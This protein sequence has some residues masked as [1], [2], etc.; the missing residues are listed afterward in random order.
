M[1]N[2]NLAEANLISQPKEYGWAD[3]NEIRYGRYVASDYIKLALYNF[4]HSVIPTLRMLEVVRWNSHDT[5]TYD[6][7]RTRI[8]IAFCITV[9]YTVSVAVNDLIIII[10]TTQ[11]YEQPLLCAIIQRQVKKAKENRSDH[12]VNGRIIHDCTLNKFCVKVWRGMNWFNTCLW[13]E[14]WTLRFH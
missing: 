8:A 14:R 10:V 2:T 13:K 12:D 11:K 5:I 9:K 6:T 3:V 4:L 7:L 1:R